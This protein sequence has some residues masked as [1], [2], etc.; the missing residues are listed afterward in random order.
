MRRSD[1]RD[2]SRVRIRSSTIFPSFLVRLPTLVR[3]VM[4]FDVLDQLRHRARMLNG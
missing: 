4:R 3:F 2:F 1:R